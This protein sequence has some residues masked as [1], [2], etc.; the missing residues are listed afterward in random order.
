MANVRCYSKKSADCS[1][2]LGHGVE[3]HT[4]NIY[5]LRTPIA[6]R[7]VECVLIINIAMQ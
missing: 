5:P 4:Y 6:L 2:E 1:K 3:F 7:L